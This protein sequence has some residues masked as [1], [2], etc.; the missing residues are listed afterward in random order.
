LPVSSMATHLHRI[1]QEAV[2]NAARHSKARR[3]DISL[4]KQ[5]GM[6]TLTVADDG[7]GLQ[8]PSSR[9]AELG[10][11]IMAYRASLIGADFRIDSTPG[12]GTCVICRLPINDLPNDQ[13]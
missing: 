3:I 5:P 2:R 11:R 8:P 9:K 4:M 6:I 7:I 1:A 13:P 12:S 10:L